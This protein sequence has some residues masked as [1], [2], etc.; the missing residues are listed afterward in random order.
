[1]ERLLYSLE[2]AAEILGISKH[3]V[4]RDARLGLIASKHYGRR[5]LIPKAEIERIGYTGLA[6]KQNKKP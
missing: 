4:A 6:P 3:T 5:I 2:E 1:M